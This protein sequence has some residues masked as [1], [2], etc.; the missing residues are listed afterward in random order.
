MRVS[1]VAEN[2]SPTAADGRAQ[3]V[4]EAEASAKKGKPFDEQLLDSSPF[5]KLRNESAETN[6]GVKHLTETIHASNAAIL[7]D[8][9]ALAANISGGTASG[10]VADVTN[11]VDLD[12]PGTYCNSIGEF[13]NACGRNIGKIMDMNIN[14][15][16]HKYICK[17]VV[18][19]PANAKFKFHNVFNESNTTILKI[20]DWWKV[21]SVCKTRPQLRVKF[22]GM[23]IPNECVAQMENSEDCLLTLVVRML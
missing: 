1:R 10:A 2:L 18:T 9:Q 23:G 20:A 22:A 16:V 14:W 3:T 13:F 21:F 7:N 11:I 8:L 15:A 12:D 5:K 17:Q 19:D 4:T 6:T